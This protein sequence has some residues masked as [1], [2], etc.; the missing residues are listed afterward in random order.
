MRKIRGE[1]EQ[2]LKKESK[3]KEEISQA[4]ISSLTVY[5]NG[6]FGK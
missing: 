4:H 6:Y 5:A 2:G 1:Q 3:R